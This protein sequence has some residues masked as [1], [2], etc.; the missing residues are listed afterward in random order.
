MRNSTT[1]FLQN[2]PA[3]KGATLLMLL[4]VMCGGLAVS[5]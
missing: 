3:R 4:I 2:L 1:R 5:A